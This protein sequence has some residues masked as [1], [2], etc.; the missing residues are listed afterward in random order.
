MSGPRLAIAAGNQLGTEAAINVAKAGGNAVDAC[1]AAAIMGWVAEPFF[2][3]I[4]G[5]GFVT[6]RTPEGSVEV[7]D[8]NNIMPF[9][10]PDKPGQGIRR[11]FLPEYAD[12]IYMGIG[13]GSVAVPGALAAV[14]SAWERHGKIEWEALFTDAIDAARRGFPFP[15]TSDYYLS[16]TWETIWSTYP[17]PKTMFADA[18]LPIQEGYTFKQPELADALQA[19]AT[20]GPEVFYE[21][22]LGREIADA[23][24]ADGGFMSVD[25][26]ANYRA[27]IRSPI[28]TNTLGWTVYSNP[29]PAVGGAVLIHMLALLEHANMD[30]DVE[31]LRSIVEAQR[32]SVGYR[33]ERYQDPDGVAAAFVEALKELQPRSQ[34]SADTTHMSSADSDGYVCSLTE[35][36]GYGAGMVV[37]GMLLNNTLGEEE[38]NP[39][40]EH[41]LPPG[42]RCHSNM[43][44]TVARGDGMTLGLGS[45]GAD[46]IVGAIAQTFLRLALDGVSIAE[47]V[48][49]PR[50][51]LDAR[52]EGE[53]LC[54]EPGLP[55]DQIGY[56]PRPYDELHMFFG[57]VQAVSVTDTGELQAAHDPRRSGGSALV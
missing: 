13:G 20:G 3:S 50:A 1:L 19:I 4:G 52:P 36:N 16:C 51:H 38:L 18:G 17:E 31:R 43:T 55:G 5:S 7:I 8:G 2:T 39:L 35:S 29:P 56:T 37:H 6:I 34:R 42:S 14:R 10:I 46:R 54:Y 21:G 27:E 22:E 15:K 28:S 47:A 33:K 40:G 26:L 12:G 57:A 53:K 23:I 49:A 25:D 9:T 11:I 32:A 48:A 30:D 44:P 45:P 24:Q 41:R